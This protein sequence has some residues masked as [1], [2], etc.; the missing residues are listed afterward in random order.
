MNVVG[1]FIAGLASNAK[2]ICNKGTQLQG[3][4]RVLTDTASSEDLRRGSDDNA[5]VSKFAMNALHAHQALSTELLM[6]QEFVTLSSEDV[7]SLILDMNPEEVFHAI[8]NQD[9]SIGD[10]ETL[11]DAYIYCISELGEMLKRQNQNADLFSKVFTRLDAC[12][13]ASANLVTLITQ[14]NESKVTI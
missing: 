5:P 10:L 7:S 14:Y 1:S 4:F 2:T 11:R 3:S 6:S 12:S 9:I 8:K 13:K